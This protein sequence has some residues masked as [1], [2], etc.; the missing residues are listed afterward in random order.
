MRYLLPYRIY[1]SKHLSLTTP[2]DDT[3]EQEL[4]AKSTLHEHDVEYLQM[5]L[6]PAGQVAPKPWSAIPELIRNRVNGIMLLKLWMTEEDIKLF[7]NL[8][9]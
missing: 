5:D 9:V 6:F 2:K 4:F 7:P 3:A 1:Y 8:K